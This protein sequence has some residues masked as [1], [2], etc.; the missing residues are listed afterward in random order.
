MVKGG[1]TYR[2]IKDHLGSPRIIVDV[3]T[4]TIVQE[5]DYDEF[6]RVIKDTSP[7]FQPFGFAGGLY[8][9][10]TGLVRFGARDYEALTGRWV[11]K[12]PIGLEGGINTY[13]YVSSDPI[14]YSDYPGLFEKEKNGKPKFTIS[15][16]PQIERIGDNPKDSDYFYTN[17]PDKR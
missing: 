11:S 12:D 13:N 9:R 1:A 17:L 14:N 7:G 5:L 2:I 6:G 4:N 15:G 8:D 3:A 10:D 16:E